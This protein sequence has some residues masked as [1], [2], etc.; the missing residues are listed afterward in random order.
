V[1]V[2]WTDD[3]DS[4]VGILSTALT[5]LRGVLRLRLA[6]PVTR[7]LLIGVASTVSYAGLYLL[8]RTA[9]GAA[10]ANALAL[11]I[12]AV[13][14][15]QANRYFTFR[16]RGRAGLARQHAAGG[17]VYLLALGLTAGALDV[18]HGLDPRPSSLLEVTVLVVASACATVSRYIA[19]RAWVFAGPGR[20]RRLLAPLTSKPSSSNL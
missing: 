11:A 14:N 10:L 8:L 17:L 7:F 9:L 13:A 1:A 18:L 3:P 4:R 15:T 16:V 2:D 20:A 19:L 12:T 5:D 6:T